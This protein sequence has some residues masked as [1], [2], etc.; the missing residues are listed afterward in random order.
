VTNGERTSQ[1]ERIK[2]EIAAEER[3]Q[4][5]LTLLLGE[6]EHET[7]RCRDALERAGGRAPE[8]ETK[9]RHMRRGQADSERAL[10][11]ST[12]KLDD[13]RRRLTDALTKS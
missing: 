13:L 7:R 4:R 12:R 1:A 6:F 5:E 8:I 10:M 11:D 3:R 2:A 9:A